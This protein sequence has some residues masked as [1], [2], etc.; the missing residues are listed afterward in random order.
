MLLT[1]SADSPVAIKY[2]T[3][4]RR[5]HTALVTNL[6]Q[7]FKAILGPKSLHL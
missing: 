2:F 6:K 5:P 1:T 7:E 3:L 4:A